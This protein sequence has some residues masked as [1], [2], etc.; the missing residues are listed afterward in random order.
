MGMGFL[1]RLYGPVESPR[2]ADHAPANGD[3][4][5]RGKSFSVE[6]II[7]D[8]KCWYSYRVVSEFLIHDKQNKTCCRDEKEKTRKR[9]YLETI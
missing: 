3:A 4:F 5:I 1:F 7:V 9:V 6:D 2:M 8:L